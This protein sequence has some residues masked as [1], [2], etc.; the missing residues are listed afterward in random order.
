MIDSAY[1]TTTG[2]KTG[3]PRQA[4]VW[5]VRRGDSFFF[6][7]HRWSMWWR[8]LESDPRGVL[9]V[10]R[11]RFEVEKV[12]ISDDADCADWVMALFREKYGAG[13]V[14]AWYEGGRRHVVWLRLRGERS[15]AP[16]LGDRS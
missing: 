8:N 4:E 15:G 5:F 6:L 12:R 7:A 2:R 3:L 11:D 9:D 14:R 10:H 13:P 1:L 16:D